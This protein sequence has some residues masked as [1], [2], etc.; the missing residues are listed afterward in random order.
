MC[1]K[2]VFLMCMLS[3]SAFV[4]AAKE[5]TLSRAEMAEIKGSCPGCKLK[6][7]DNESCRSTS[8]TCEGCFASSCQNYKIGGIVKTMYCDYTGPQN[9]AT[10]TEAA[11]TTVCYTD[12]FCLTSPIYG[13]CISG[14]NCDPWQSGL[15]YQCTAYYIQPPATMLWFYC[16]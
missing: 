5:K 10:C 9:D 15:C 12:V 1:R 11:H 4:C 8:G 14:G 2:K 6:W 13:K 3:V 16:K 7:I